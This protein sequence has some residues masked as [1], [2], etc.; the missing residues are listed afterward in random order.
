MAGSP[1][2][3]ARSRK[4]MRGLAVISG[5]G[6]ADDALDLGPD[7]TFDQRRQ[8]G[9]K[10]LLEQGLHLVPHNVLERRPARMDLGRPRG[11]RANK[12]ADRRSGGGGGGGRNQWRDGGTGGSLAGR[13]RR[14]RRVH[15]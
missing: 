2:A 14:S 13:G 9:V 8:I 6:A 3:S 12:A 1:A 4:E 11:Q 15:V 7:E 10:P 5:V